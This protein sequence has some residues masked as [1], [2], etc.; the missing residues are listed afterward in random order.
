MW[1]K[2]YTP[3]MLPLRNVINNGVKPKYYVEGTHEAI[4]SMDDFKM[5]QQIISQHAKNEK[6]QKKTHFFPVGV[7]CRHCGWSFSRKS[8][9]PHLIACNKKG[10]SGTECPSRSYSCEEL[11]D[12]FIRMYNTLRQNEHRILDE[13]LSRL[14]DF[15]T[16]LTGQDEQIAAID[17]DIALLCEQSEMYAKLLTEKVIDQV[18]YAEKCDIYKRRISELRTRRRKL[19]SEDEDE[20]C[21]TCLRKLKIT[22][23][24]MPRRLLIVT[25]KQIKAMTE[26][27][28]AEEDGSLT[29]VLCGELELNVKMDTVWH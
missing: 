26:K 18:T 24:E 22:L 10:L 6:P 12:A 13:T 3:Q 4:I 17:S 16:K 1:Q 15:K 19:M 11:S 5:V 9:S 27:I 2:T 23:G 8:S 7:V 29:F 20:H 28:Y 25:D 14:H 21:I